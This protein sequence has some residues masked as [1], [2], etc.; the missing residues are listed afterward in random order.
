MLI[1]VLLAAAGAVGGA[2]S[3]TR[4]GQPYPAA[5]SDWAFMP[6]FYIALQLLTYLGA[7]WGWFP[8]GGYGDNFVDHLYHLFLPTLTLGFNMARSCCITCAHRSSKC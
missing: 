8:I 7:R 5:L 6:T 1:S 3:C 4:S 2:A